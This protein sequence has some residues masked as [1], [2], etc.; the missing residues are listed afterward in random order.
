MFKV[1]L[2]FPAWGVH[3]RSK[4]PI[5]WSPPSGI[6]LIAALGLVIIQWVCNQNV[7]RKPGN[8]K[9]SLPTVPRE[10]PLLDWSYVACNGG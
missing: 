4:S 2:K 6:T 1:I 5:P 10:E 3:E 8:Y 9:L 7:K